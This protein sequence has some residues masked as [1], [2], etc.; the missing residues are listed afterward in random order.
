MGESFFLL[1]AIGHT[2]DPNTNRPSLKMHK[3]LKATFLIV[4]IFMGV[5]F[6]VFYTENQ[7]F[8][9]LLFVVAEAFI[10]A[11][12]IFESVNINSA[13]IFTT[14]FDAYALQAFKLNSIDY[15]LKPIDEDELK[16]A[17]AKYQN[18][19]QE[20]SLQNF[21]FEDI[22]NM[23]YRD[24]E[25]Y[26]NRYT[27]QVGSHIKILA[28]SEIVCFYSENKGTYALMESGRSFLMEQTIESLVK[29]LDPKAFFRISRK[30]IIQIAHIRDIVAFSNARLKIEIKP[31][32]DIDLVVSR[33]R[34]KDFKLWIS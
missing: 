15:L 14:A 9:S 16:T 32:I 21:D 33:E 13:I 2:F 28:V 1:L 29:E 12:S 31:E 18:I 26:K 23:L 4:L 27:A 20:S 19:H 17:V 11:F 22:K 30:C 8:E 24:K 5:Y 3:I 6:S 34:V 10:Y 7:S 25:V